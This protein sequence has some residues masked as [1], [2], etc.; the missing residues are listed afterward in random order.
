MV[1][2]TTDISRYYKTH[3]TDEA[4]EAQRSEKTNSGSDSW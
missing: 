1:D 4:T 3:Y 2:T